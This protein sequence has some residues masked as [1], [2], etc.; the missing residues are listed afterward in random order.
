MGKMSNG[1]NVENC[2]LKFIYLNQTRRARVTEAE[3]KAMS[4]SSICA[5]ARSLFPELSVAGHIVPDK[6]IT[7][8]WK[9]EE[10]EVVTLSSSSE[11]SVAM[12]SMQSRGQIVRFDVDVI[13]AEEFETKA[14]E[15]ATILPPLPP[16]TPT[17]R[18]M[19]SPISEEFLEENAIASGKLKTDKWSIYQNGRN[20][21]FYGLAGRK[22]QT[23]EWAVWGNSIHERGETVTCRIQLV[24]KRKE[25]AEPSSSHIHAWE[26]R[27]H[28]KRDD[29][30]TRVC[31]HDELY[32]YQSELVLTPTSG[33]QYR[34][35]LK[36]PRGSEGRHARLGIMPS[37]FV[38][39]EQGD[40]RDEGSTYVCLH[41]S[42]Y[43]EWRFIRLPNGKF[44]IQL[45]GSRKNEHDKHGSYLHVW[46]CYPLDNR[47]EGSTRL[48]VHD[49]LY[50]EKS[51]W[52]V[53]QKFMR[54]SP[55]CCYRFLPGRHV[56]FGNPAIRFEGENSTIIDI[57]RWSIKEEN[58][59]LV[60]RDTGSGGDFRYA[61]YPGQFM[62]F[63][64][65]AVP[66]SFTGVIT[67]HT[68]LRWHIQEE[69][70][71]LVFRDTKSQGDCR[72]AFY[73]NSGL[74]ELNNSASR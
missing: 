18:L 33:D 31:V 54:D 48:C 44:N 1:D 61:F 13:S 56:N 30:S 62:D 26:C 24:G 70:G 46:E 60:I 10:L 66:S 3:A 59:V 63:G 29:S 67:L 64:T 38:S 50:G 15:K 73:P 27:P 58:G 25:G 20:L 74:H 39:E 34:I 23:E 69:N 19:T 5:L 16:H 37:L 12:Q 65:P 6:F 22:S 42:K 68:G 35:Q 41:E 11:L 4:F 36:G 49:N 14:K 21:H 55:I 52:T 17:P 71:V 40:L 8:K 32:G 28:D 43:S 47:D 9:D 72:I 45:V 2:D 51:E 53:A 57:Y 7:L